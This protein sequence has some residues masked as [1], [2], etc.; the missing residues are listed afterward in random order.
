LIAAIMLVVGVLVI[1]FSAVLLLTGQS[2]FPLPIETSSQISA[3]SEQW[4]GYVARSSLLVPQATVTS[5][6]GSWIVPAI[7]A[8]S[9]DTYSGVWVG[10][11]GFGEN[12]LIQAGTLQQCADGRVTYYAWYE[13]LPALAVRISD[14]RIR[15]GDTISASIR[16]VDEAE[17]T[18]SVEI[19]D[20]AGG[21]SFRRT[22]VYNSSRLSGEWI[23]ERPTINQR[24]SNLSDFGSVTFS[25]CYATLGNTT[26]TITEFK[27]YKL[28]MYTSG[29]VHL[30][31]VTSLSSDGSSFTVTRLESQRAPRQQTQGFSLNGFALVVECKK[32]IRHRNRI[33]SLT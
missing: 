3:R 7:P 6:S 11:G 33:T 20:V 31:N 17:D 18:W 25:E 27:R 13:L 22:F 15:A 9:G 12:T 16:L 30:A 14:L 32:E 5:V 4:A 1:Y 10:I 29:N 24:V 19:N 21:E 23:V 8:T 2:I 28:D 26:G